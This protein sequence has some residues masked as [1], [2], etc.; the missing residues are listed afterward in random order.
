M[1]WAAYVCHAADYGKSGVQSSRQDREQKDQVGAE[2]EIGQ[3]KGK[4]VVF[5]GDAGLNLVTC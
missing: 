1:T 4:G 3:G 5:R 2:K